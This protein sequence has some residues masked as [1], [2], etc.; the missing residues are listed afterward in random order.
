MR[1]CARPTAVDGDGASL[2]YRAMTTDRGGAT[3][4]LGCDRTEARVAPRTT[5]LMNFKP[6]AS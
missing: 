5:A 1:F 6:N 2:R 4:L 3:E